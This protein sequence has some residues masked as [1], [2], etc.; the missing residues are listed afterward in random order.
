MEYTEDDLIEAYKKL[1]TKGGEIMLDEDL[2]N[3]FRIRTVQRKGD[4]IIVDVL[5]LPKASVKYINHTFKITKNGFTE[6]CEGD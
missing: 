5:V 6:Y 2:I 4:N 3:D 1:A